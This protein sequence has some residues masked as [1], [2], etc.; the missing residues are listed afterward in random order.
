MT[1]DL[2]FGA[3][4]S[5]WQDVRAKWLLERQRRNPKSDEGIVTAFRD[6]QVT[7]RENR[8]TDGFTNALQEIGYQGIREGDLVVHGM[9][10]F[11]GA[12]G[13]SDSDGKA[14]PVVHA[15]RSRGEVDVR[16]VAYLLRILARSGYIA[17]L[18]K[19]IR[20]RSTAFDAA[21]LA[22]VVLPT[23]SLEEQRRIA[24]FLDAETSR[25]D[26]L[27]E[28]YSA[29]PGVL[30]ERHRAVIDGQMA[31]CGDVVPM[32]YVV[33]FREGPG[34][35]AEDFRDEGTPLVRI[36]GLRDGV[37][38]LGGC[39]FLDPEKVDK[40]WSQFRLKVGDRLLSGSATLGAVSIVRDPKVEGA[41]PYTGLIIL[42]PIS[43][44]DMDF[45]EAFL[46]SSNFANQIDILKAGA[47]MQH[48]GPT[49]LSQI[50]MPMVSLAMQQDIARTVKSSEGVLRHAVN[51]IQRQV[52]LLAERRQALI[53]AAVTGQLDI[54]TASGRN[55]T[56]GV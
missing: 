53:T 6:G 7:L 10:G 3:L 29:I 43:D 23:P 40:R 12:I 30:H 1:G 54:T 32:R 5:T 18:A 37:V 42:R 26:R 9:D 44:V 33:K 52:A 38:T 16:Y 39:N 34:I 27:A 31:T 8:R 25:I 11:A 20:E 13:V 49:H 36:A 21:T 48:F 45:V 22:N 51:R 24:D 50:K 2:V 47:T 4:P 56:Q 17:T 41:I 19:G 28:L 14:S 15:Y 46:E 55:L 35:M